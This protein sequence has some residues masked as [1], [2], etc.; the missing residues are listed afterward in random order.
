MHVKWKTL[1]AVLA[2]AAS[3]ASILVA[4]DSTGFT[5]V[6][7]SPAQGQ[8]DDKRLLAADKHPGEW[9]T[10]GRDFG[11]GHYSPLDQINASNVARLGLSWQYD[12]HTVLGL[13][14]TPIVVD[15]VM[16]TSGSVG[17]VY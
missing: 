1:G 8:V 2:L 15:G 16:Y 7:A 14:A 11:K 3:L 6:F 4:L 13:E 10:T 12:T 9:L 17:Q 5:S